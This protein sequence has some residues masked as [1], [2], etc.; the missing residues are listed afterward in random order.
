[1]GHHRRV[2]KPPRPATPGLTG[3]ASPI[4]AAVYPSLGPLLVV[5]F[6]LVLA[7]AFR[8]GAE[9]TREVDDLV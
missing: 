6:L 5:P 3:P 1:M 7:E 8:R 2:R 9:L 4:F